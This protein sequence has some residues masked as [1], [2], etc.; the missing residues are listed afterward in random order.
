MGRPKASERIRDFAA[1]FANTVTANSTRP[2]DWVA[3]TGEFSMFTL[4]MRLA[5]NV[6]SQIK[7]LI[8]YSNLDQICCLPVNS[9]VGRTKTKQVLCHLRLPVIICAANAVLPDHIICRWGIAEKE[10]NKYLETIGFRRVRIRMKCIVRFV[11]SC[12]CRLPR[13]SITKM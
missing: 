7:I 6:R 4:L 12:F 2:Y 5:P 11:F 13:S 8:R 10:L 9:A 3:R 1:T